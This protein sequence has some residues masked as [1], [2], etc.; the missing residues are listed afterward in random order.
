MKRFI[1][2]VLSLL[3][4]SSIFLS[5]CDTNA[6]QSTDKIP[7]E[8]SSQ[9][10]E[11][12]KPDESAKPDESSKPGESSKPNNPSGSDEQ[13]AHRHQYTEEVTAPSCTKQGFT[14][15][16]CPGCG[17]SYTDAYTEAKGHRI[18]GDQ[19]A[20]CGVYDFLQAC[21][22]SI[23]GPGKGDI[24]D[25]SLNSFVFQ[26]MFQNS[27]KDFVCTDGKISISIKTNNVEVFQSDLNFTKAD[28]IEKEIEDGVFP[29][30]EVGIPAERVIAADN[31]I[32]FGEITVVYM[33]GTNVRNTQNYY[34]QTFNRSSRCGRSCSCRR[35]S[36]KGIEGQGIK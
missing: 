34:E 22:L 12:T 16:T 33:G 30:L 5:G 36:G 23:N 7:P 18:E 25:Q 3:I 4:G 17:E 28:F 10:N 26:V 6:A 27:Q 32:P 24:Y 8:Q 15:H 29:M 1:C 35:S 21:A 31:L 9:P 2:I 11:P 14:T 13:Q 20:E 19:C